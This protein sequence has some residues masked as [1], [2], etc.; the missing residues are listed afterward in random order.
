MTAFIS[1]HNAAGAW[2][3]SV[4]ADPTAFG[5]E[6]LLLVLLWAADW[7]VRKVRE[8]WLKWTSA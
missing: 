6:L 7:A 1:A 3:V 2:R 4:G 5:G 8:A